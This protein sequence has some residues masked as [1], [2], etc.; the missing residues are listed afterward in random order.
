MSTKRVRE[1]AIRILFLGVFVAVV[2]IV[3]LATASA[4]DP[5]SI[6]CGGETMTPGT[7]CGNYRDG[8]VSYEDAVR[9][10]QEGI[11]SRQRNGPVVALIGGVVALGAGLVL[12]STAG[13]GG[14]ES[15]PGRG[16]SG[17]ATT[18]TPWW[19]EGDRS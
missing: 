3:M 5:T 15:S 17:T 1:V 4:D 8:W 14:R 16:P 10:Q 19:S 12:A 9:G 2:G 11:A 18:S 6:D 13:D 7:E